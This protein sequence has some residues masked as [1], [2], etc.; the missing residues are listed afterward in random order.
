[1]NGSWCVVV[2]RWNGQ[3]R[4]GNTNDYWYAVDSD[5]SEIP[6]SGWLAASELLSSNVHVGVDGPGPIIV[7]SGVVV[8]G[9]GSAPANGVYNKDGDYN[10]RPMY[11]CS[12]T[13][14]QIWCVSA[15][16]CVHCCIISSCLTLV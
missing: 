11:T 16:I 2:G 9:A 7:T 8:E 3:W 1:M 6:T 5:S 10:S 4:L 15:V 13:G 14:M 12:A